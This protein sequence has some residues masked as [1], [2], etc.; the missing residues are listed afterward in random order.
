MDIVNE[1]KFIIELSYLFIFFLLTSLDFHLDY[2]LRLKADWPVGIPIGSGQSPW[3]EDI[4][5]GKVKWH[6]GGLSLV[7]QGI[8]SLICVVLIH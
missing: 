4:L 8:W 3:E 7:L 6:N 1:V 5:V 2:F